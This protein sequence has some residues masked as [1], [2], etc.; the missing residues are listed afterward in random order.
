VKGPSV[1]TN[2]VKCQ[3]TKLK[4]KYF[5]FFEDGMS[6]HYFFDKESKKFSRHNITSAG[7]NSFR[8]KNGRFPVDSELKEIDS[9][10]IAEIKKTFSKELKLT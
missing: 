10:S 7:M 4:W 6:Y 3:R 2:C 9:I 1:N 5:C 8:I